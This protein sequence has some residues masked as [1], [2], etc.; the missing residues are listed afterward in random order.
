MSHRPTLATAAAL[1]LAASSHAAVLD[2]GGSGPIGSMT[3]ELTDLASDPPTLEASGAFLSSASVSGE[4]FDDA[5]GSLRFTADAYESLTVEGD[6]S[7][8]LG[9]NTGVTRST[10]D[11]WGV[12]G[13]PG[14]DIVTG[15]LLLSFD[16]ADLAAFGDLDAAADFAPPP[17]FD[18]VLTG[19]TISAV[20]TPT[21]SVEGVSSQTFTSGTEFTGLDV[22]IEDGT[23]LAFTNAGGDAF[24]LD[25]ITL[26]VVP[27]PGTAAISAA[28]LAL[29]ARRRKR[30]VA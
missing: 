24:R 25:T 23:R 19:F 17:G 9:G 1:T 30:A 29:I 3:F 18:L 20:S 15:A 2:F 22:V 5:T 14:G 28:G 11:G 7:F 8:T 27:E 21:L 4:G 26:A 6:G 10:T 16:L 13:D 12:Q